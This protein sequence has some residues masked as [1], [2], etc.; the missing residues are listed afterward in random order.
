[1][2]LFIILINAITKLYSAFQG[3]STE[4]SQVTI[5]NDLYGEHTLANM[6]DP[7]NDYRFD[8]TIQI[9]TWEGIDKKDLIDI[10]RVPLET[11]SGIDLQKLERYVLPILSV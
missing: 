4:F 5:N 8:A 10:Y 1:M 2:A 3:E 11:S 6:S 7:D 9:H